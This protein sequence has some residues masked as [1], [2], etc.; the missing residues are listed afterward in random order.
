[1]NEPVGIV[2]VSHSAALAAGLAD[3]LA[4]IGSTAVPV[5]TAGGTEDGR[6][7]TSY[8]LVVKA[9]DRADQGGGVLVLPDL[10]SS[11]LTARAVVEDRPRAGVA[12]VDAP[13]VEGA[14]AAAVTAA[15]GGDLDAVVT[16]AREAR[17]V[18]KS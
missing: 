16:A 17:D 13:F 15:A 7:G 12:V 10:G 18:H 2:L 14:V 3:L 5:E 8:D 9:I 6:L 4:Q 11:V 1:M